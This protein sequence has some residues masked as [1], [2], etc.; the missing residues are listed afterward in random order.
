MTSIIKTKYRS[1]AYDEATLN[2]VDFLENEYPI[3]RTYLGEVTFVNL[4]LAMIGTR[5]AEKINARSICEQLPRFLTS[6]K[7]SNHRLEINELA[8]LELALHTAFSAPEAEALKTG[9]SVHPSVQRLSFS[10]NT[11]SIWSA[12]KCDSQPPR[13]HMLDEPQAVI[14]W[15]Q[16]Q[17][18]RFRILGNEEANA[19]DT[20]A[21]LLSFNAIC[22]NTLWEEGA[23]APAQRCAL[24]LE[25]WSEAEILT[26]P[27][28][29]VPKFEK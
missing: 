24:Y 21:K 19:F 17:S 27:A 14:V 28:G 15:R 8:T 3:L 5:S 9:I 1:Q 7:I 12:L 16:S 25:G 6:C 4:T 26:F 2:L 11:V 13:P 20:A 10:Q 22:E 29:F 18:A 23:L